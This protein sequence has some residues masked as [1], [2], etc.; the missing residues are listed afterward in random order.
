MQHTKSF[1]PNTNKF[2]DIFKHVI[3]P[4]PICFASTVDK[5]GNVNLSPFSFFNMMGQNPPICVFSPLRKMRDGTTK[6]TLENIWEHPECVINIVNYNIVQQQSLASVEY[7][8]GVNEFVKAGFTELASELV[9]PP[10]V[11]ESP[12]QLECKVREVISITDQP[13]AAN[14]VI[15]EVVRLHIHEDLL[16]ENDKVSPY[17]LDLVARMGGDY[18]CRVIPESIFEVEKPTRTV[19]LG[20]DQLPDEIKH[21]NY[22]SG[23]NLGQLGNVEKLP[24]DEMIQ[25]FKAQLTQRLDIQKFKSIEVR[26]QVAAKLLEQGDVNGAWYWLLMKI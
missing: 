23:N 22:L 20:I 6:H 18:Y 8:K 2:D 5:D 4:R 21:S 25:N 16:D 19:G 10:R 1:E 17:D 15:A 12:V 13:G 14:L 26:H 9:K 7:P 3:S 24:T 11:A